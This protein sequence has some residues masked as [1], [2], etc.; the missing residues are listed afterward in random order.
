MGRIVPYLW[1]DTEAK[2]AVEFYMSLFEDS[3]MIVAQ[4]LEDT[5]SDKNVAFYEFKLA[6]MRTGAFNGGPFFKLNSSI[7]FMVQCDTKEEVQML[8]DKLMDGGKQ[9]MPLQVYDFSEFY[10]WVEDRYGVSWQL[11]SAEG[12][13]YKQKILPSLLFSGP[14]T[15][16]ARE[17]M[18][19]YTDIFQGGKI[20]NAFEYEKGQATHLK[21][22]VSYAIFEIMGTEMVVGDHAEEVEETFNEAFSFMILCVTKGEIDYYWEKLSSDSEAEQCGWLKDKYGVSWQVVPSNLSELL[23]TGTRAQMKAVTQAFLS[24][25][26]LDLE[27]LERAWA[28][29]A[30]E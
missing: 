29:A 9:L 2:E 17:A 24:M 5:P 26:K 7:S 10:G 12:M 1:Y 21:A 15:G 27:K 16:K 11:I 4:E 18:S 20:L 23:S 19:Y 13:P 25:K 30:E 3:E 22:E 14:V 8:W 28:I 6:G